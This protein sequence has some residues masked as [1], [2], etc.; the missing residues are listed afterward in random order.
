MKLYGSKPSPYVRRLRLL[1][2]EIEH[3]FVV[4]D[5]YA[6]KDRAMLKKHNPTL[7]IPML[8]DNTQIVLDSRVIFN[9]LADKGLVESINVEQENLLTEVDAAGDSF[10]QMFLLKRSGIDT[11]ADALYFKLQR[12]RIEAVFE[13]L[14]HMVNTQA[15][16]E[17]HFLCMSLFALI[18]WLAFR[19]LFELSSY[20]NLMDFHQRC[21]S[22]ESVQQTDPRKD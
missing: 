16:K 7:K 19:E 21:L 6:P 4:V 3:E 14:E 22:I 8:D 12:E 11:E 1:M 15:F 17:W 5:I 10:V 20:P 13:H 2:A 18:D 9:Y